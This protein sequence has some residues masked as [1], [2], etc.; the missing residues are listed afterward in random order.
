MS[1]FDKT[2]KEMRR[3]H[4]KWML[5]FVVFTLVVGGVFVW[6]VKETF[7]QLEGAGK[8]EYKQMRLKDQNILEHAEDKLDEWAGVPKK[9]PQK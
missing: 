4:L 2:V 8:A 1:E 3:R 9:E 5:V 7:K 6:S